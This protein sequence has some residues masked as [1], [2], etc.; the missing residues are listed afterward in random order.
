[1]YVP[2]KTIP[3]LLKE[4]KVS[5]GFSAIFHLKKKATLLGE[6][7]SDMACSELWVHVHVKAK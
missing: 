1:M 6:E 5:V 2:H 3:Q 7:I 4:R